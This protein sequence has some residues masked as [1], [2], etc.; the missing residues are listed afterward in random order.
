MRAEERTAGGPSSS[1]GPH[2]IG[3]RA[4]ADMEARAEAVLFGEMPNEV[5]SQAVRVLARTPAGIDRMIA[6][7]QA[8]RSRP[9]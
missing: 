1:R 4:P 2:A 7:E 8:G 3:M 6:M 9:S 5:R